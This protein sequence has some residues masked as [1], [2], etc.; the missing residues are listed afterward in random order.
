MKN[1]IIILLTILLTAT[2]VLSAEKKI[3]VNTAISN[4]RKIAT[5]NRFK[6]ARFMCEHRGCLVD[7]DITSKIEN[8]LNDSAKNVKLLSYSLIPIDH[9]MGYTHGFLV[10]IQYELY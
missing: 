5:K 10:T 1:I 8:Y 9:D 4:E 2:T 6:I 7:S 3:V